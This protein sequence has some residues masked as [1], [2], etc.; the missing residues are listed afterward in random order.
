MSHFATVQTRLFWFSQRFSHWLSSR[1]HTV[2][3]AARA[4][5]RPPPLPP[6]IPTFSHKSALL[7]LLYV[8]WM[9][10]VGI[11]ARKLHHLETLVT[12]VCMKPFAIWIGSS[13]VSATQR[14]F[15]EYMVRWLVPW[16]HTQW[17][18]SSYMESCCES[19]CHYFSPNFT[20]LQPLSRLEHLC[21]KEDH[22][23]LTRMFIPGTL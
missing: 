1:F 8:K 13:L 2:S 6:S 22:Q 16:E 23:Y 15:T 14:N 11:T 18:S 9:T 12:T 3:F 17:N 10:S 5:Y 4:L 7:I 20:W 19:L 21:L